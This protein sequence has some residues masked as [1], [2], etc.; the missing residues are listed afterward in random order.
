MKNNCRY[1]SIVTNIGINSKL[2]ETTTNYGMSNIQSY[3]FSDSERIILD[4]LY[5]WG[6]GHVTWSHDQYVGIGLKP[7]LMKK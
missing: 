6:I 4:N 2:P 1:I 5:D 7:S 3:P